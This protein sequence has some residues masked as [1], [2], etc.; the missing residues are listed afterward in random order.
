MNRR[1][2]R[3][4]PKN[5]RPQQKT[6]PSKTVHSEAILETEPVMAKDVRFYDSFQ[7]AYHDVEKLPDLERDIIIKTEGSMND[8]KLLPK[9]RVF[10]GT[11]W[12]I[13]FQRRVEEG[14]YPE[15]HVTKPPTVKLELESKY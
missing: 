2:F 11:A 9:G 8:P 7:E 1:R 14:F 5:N 6:G 12:W 3:H 15:E 4:R 13:I 10:A